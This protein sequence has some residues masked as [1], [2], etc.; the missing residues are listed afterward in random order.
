MMYDFAT[1]SI[2]QLTPSNTYNVWPTIDGD[3]V[4]YGRAPAGSGTVQ[5]FAYDIPSRTETQIATISDNG[6][7]FR[8]DGDRLVWL[9]RKNDRWDIYL[10]DFRTGTQARITGDAAVPSTPSIVGDRI[11][12]NDRR[13]NDVWADIY[14]YDIST[15][16]EQRITASST[17]MRGPALT[18]ERIVW[19]DFRGNAPVPSGISLLYEYDFENPVHEHLLQ[20]STNTEKDDLAMGGS[21]LAWQERFLSYSVF[22]YDFTT[23]TE[24]QV[25]FSRPNVWGLT[26]AG[27]YMLWTQFRDHVGP[28]QGQL[29]VARL[30][31]LFP[32]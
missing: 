20:T 19:E 23:S 28:G 13:A 8:V 5:V 31:A 4:V 16:V 7:Y 10:Y 21:Y 11:A 25:T 1:D 29:Y 18:D 12:W 9:D 24:R 15:G 30:S 27:D 2:T 3:R 17:V 32:H 14:M 6:G 26:V 22:A